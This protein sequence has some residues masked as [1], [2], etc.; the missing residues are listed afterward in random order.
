MSERNDAKLLGE[1]RKLIDFCA[2]EPNFKPPNPICELAAMEAKYTEGMTAVADVSAKIVPFKVAVNERQQAFEDVP[3]LGSRI[4]RMAKAADASDEMLA[5]M[6]TYVRKLRGGR[7]GKKPSDDPNT[8]ENEAGKSHSVSQ[9]SYGAKVEHFRNI[10][11]LV[12]IEPLYTPNEDELK[13]VTLDA[14]IADLEVKNNAVSSSYVPLSNSRSFRDQLLYLADDSVVDTA[15]LTKQ[16]VEAAFGRNSTL[17]GQISG[18]KFDRN[19]R[20]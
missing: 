2:A 10:V 18:L 16:Y 13:T 15:L 14:K 20:D 6:Q 3:T 8:P 7:A 12:K 4:Y 11:G 1:F 17:Y 19:K 9:L 5:D